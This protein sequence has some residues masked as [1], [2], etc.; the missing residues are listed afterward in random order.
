MARFRYTTPV[1]FAEVDHAGIVYYPR[2]FHYFHL[3]FEEFFRTRLGAGAYLD[4]IDR[5]RIGFPAVRS[6][7]DYRAP[8]RFGDTV[9]I[10]MWIERLGGKSIRFRYQAIRAAAGAGEGGEPAAG[11]GEE[12]VVCADGAVVCAVTDLAHFRAV[13]VPPDLR[14]LFLELVGDPG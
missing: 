10:D 5:R 6:E 3:A 7:C 13:E 12:E 14:A 2:F 11:P 1:R 4:L 9:H 8:L